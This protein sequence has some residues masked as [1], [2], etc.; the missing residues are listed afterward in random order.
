MTKY[1]QTN[2]TSKKGINYIKR[3]IKSVNC[4]FHSIHQENDIGL[5][6]IIELNDNSGRKGR[7][8]AIQVKSGK[9]FFTTKAGKCK[10]NISDHR[11]YWLNHDLDVYGIVY[12]PELF[13]AFYVDIKEYINNNPKRTVITFSTAPENEFNFENFGNSINNYRPKSLDQIKLYEEFVNSIENKMIKI[14]FNHLNIS[15]N[16]VIEKMMVSSSFQELL[17]KIGCNIVSATERDRIKVEIGMPT[18]S[19]KEGSFMYSI[20]R[21]IYLDNSSL[22]FYENKFQTLKNI[23]HG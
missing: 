18:C 4:E 16:L 13:K 21:D 20:N 7:L 15:V 5:D 1:L 10:I 11:E 3:V 6:A 8:V 9:S 12:I 23:I 17:I 2:A 14:I 22:K 19:N